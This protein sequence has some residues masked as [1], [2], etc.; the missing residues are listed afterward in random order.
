EPD[1][2]ERVLSRK[3][4]KTATALLMAAMTALLVACGGGSD[5]SNAGDSLVIGGWGGTIDKATQKHYIDKY[6]E[7]GGAVKDFTFVDAPSAQLAR[8]EA[9]NKAG[10]IEW[11]LIDSAPGPEAY[12]LNSKGLLA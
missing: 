8:V 4:K 12:L 3:W 9:Q 1:S 6:V 11:D 2:K 7:E 5:S 10:N